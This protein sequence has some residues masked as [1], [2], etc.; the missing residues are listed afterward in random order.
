MDKLYLSEGTNETIRAAVSD[1]CPGGRRPG[2]VQKSF[3][4]KQGGHA[5]DGASV[6]GHALV[7]SAVDACGESVDGRSGT[8]REPEAVETGPSRC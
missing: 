2:G 8:G 4:K 3:W 5:A 1:S 7:D 6:V